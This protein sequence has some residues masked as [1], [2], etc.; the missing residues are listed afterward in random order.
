[1]ATSW[2][3]HY[4]RSNTAKLNK[5]K[6]KQNKQNKQNKNKINQMKQK[7]QNFKFIP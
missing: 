1:M 3:G 6:I 5:I 2:Q 7:E 4:T